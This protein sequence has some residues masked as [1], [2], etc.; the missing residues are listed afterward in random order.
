MDEPQ[1]SADAWRAGTRAAGGHGSQFTSS[2]IRHPQLPRDT[3]EAAIQTSSELAGSFGLT[4]AFDLP[5]RP[6]L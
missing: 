2:G 4:G 5:F 1:G 6:S 3:A